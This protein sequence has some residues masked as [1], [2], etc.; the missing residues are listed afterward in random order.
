MASDYP[1]SGYD[2]RYDEWGSGFTDDDDGYDDDFSGG[3]K[4]TIV[5]YVYP[6]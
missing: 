5:M 4:Y 1:G 3:C 2:Q 6:Q